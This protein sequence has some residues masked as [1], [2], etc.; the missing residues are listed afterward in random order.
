M[1]CDPKDKVNEKRLTTI[2]AELNEL[3]CVFYAKYIENAN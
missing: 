3:P 1:L 2:E